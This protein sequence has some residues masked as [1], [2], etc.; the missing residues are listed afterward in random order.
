[1]S[2]T[3]ITPYN[4]SDKNSY[5]YER[6]K[7]FLQESYVSDFSKRIFVDFSSSKDIS[8]E[9]EPIAKARGIRYIRLNRHGE[10]YSSGVCR[11][12]GAIEA[13]TQFI[14]FQDVDLF[15]NDSVYKA[16]ESRLGK[17]KYFNELELIPC[18]YLTENFSREYLD[19]T[20]Y[21]QNFTIHQAY[22]E[23]DKEII[24]MYAPASSCKLLDRKFYLMSGGMHKEFYGHGFEDFE[25]HYRL[26]DMSKKYYKTHEPRSHNYMYDSLDY[27]GYRTFFSMFGRPLMDEGLYFVHLWHDN[28][29]G[30]N[31]QK[32]NR[33]NRGIFERLMNE[34]DSGKSR[35]TP[36]PNIHAKE[37]ILILASKKSI[38]ATSLKQLFV[39]IG[40]CEFVDEKIIANSDSLKELV[41]DKQY[42]RVFF[43]NPYGNEHRLSLYRGCKEYGIPYYVFD[44]GALNNSWFIDP[45]GFNGDSDS[46][47]RKRWD[48]E[49][50]E[51]QSIEVEEYI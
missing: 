10:L 40:N 36:L 19:M 41:E 29:V 20:D 50:T 33:I 43:F 28:H 18:L 39:E 11:N 44:R 34:Y 14:S 30:T 37:N 16:I 2:L 49:L 8:D 4:C 32:R 9:L 12:V 24:H 6:A 22:L 26:C 17:Y 3:Y 13:D 27:K 38:N 46:Y 23:N 47:S 48:H 51:E 21:D 5:L 15:A 25:L 42:D 45:N 1:M 35:I 31:Y 7:F